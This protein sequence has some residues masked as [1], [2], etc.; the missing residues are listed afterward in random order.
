MGSLLHLTFRA[1][2]NES[3]T[4]AAFKRLFRIQEPKE[5]DQLGDH[6]CPSRLVAC[7]SLSCYKLNIVALWFILA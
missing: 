3:R 6:S 7:A 1:S 4:L 5:L 2:S